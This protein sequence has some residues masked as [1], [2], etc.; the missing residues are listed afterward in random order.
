[1][2]LTQKVARFVVAITML[3]V[4]AMG[5]QRT[6]SSSSASMIVAGD[7]AKPGAGGG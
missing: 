7:D 5:V 1:M 6:L 2:Q 3:A 4:F